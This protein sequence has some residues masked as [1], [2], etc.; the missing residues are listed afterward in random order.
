MEKMEYLEELRR[1]LQTFPQWGD[2]AIY[3]DDLAVRPQNAGLYP[4]G[5]EILEKKEDLLGNRSMRCRQ[6]FVLYKLS[7]PG[8]EAS[9]WLLQL[10]QWVAEQSALGLAPRFGDVPAQ[11]VIRAEKGALKERTAAGTAVYTVTITTEFV[12]KFEG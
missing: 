6:R 2:A 4:V 7:T 5:L 11:E 8:Q 1:W 12:K 9:A 10:Q 3:I